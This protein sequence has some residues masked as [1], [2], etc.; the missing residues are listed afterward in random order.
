MH[1]ISFCSSRMHCLAYIKKSQSLQMYVQNL[2]LLIP[3]TW[4]A[5]IRNS[6]SYLTIIIIVVKPARSDSLVW[7]LCVCSSM[8]PHLACPGRNF[9]ICCKVRHQFYLVEL[10]TLT[11]RNR[12]R[13]TKKVWSDLVVK[14][15]IKVNG[16]IRTITIKTIWVFQKCSK[17]V[18][19]DKTACR[20][21]QPT[22]MPQRVWSY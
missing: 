19:R 4:L 20:F 11:R 6:L 16:Q 13:L 14:W 1:I 5:Y 3:N 22:C 12:H 17:N 9:I 10:L 2:F 7:C 18:K 8:R 21:K 15:Q